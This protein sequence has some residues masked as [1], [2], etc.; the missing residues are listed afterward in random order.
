MRNNRMIGGATGDGRAILAAVPILGVSCAFGRPLGRRL[1]GYKTA[2][3]TCRAIRC[4]VPSA[5]Q[6]MWT[7]K[8]GSGVMYTQ[9]AGGRANFGSRLRMG[10]VRRPRG[11]A[12]AKAECNDGIAAM[13]LREI[14]RG[15]AEWAQACEASN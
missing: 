12:K 6:A 5:Y 15:A 7:R 8:H 1:V 14:F 11:D 4:F 9:G 13:A 10:T 3:I 2:A